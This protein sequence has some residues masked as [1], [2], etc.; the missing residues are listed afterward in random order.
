MQSDGDPGAAP[1]SDPDET[2]TDTEERSLWRAA[3]VAVGEEAAPMSE[4]AV[5][6]PVLPGARYVA[7]ELIGAGGM[8]EVRLC[9][10]EAIGRDV[11]QKTMLAAHERSREQ[12]R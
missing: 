6:A 5:G 7:R 11:A 8:G 2:L 10:D 1:R 3:T 12:Q 9:R 4:V